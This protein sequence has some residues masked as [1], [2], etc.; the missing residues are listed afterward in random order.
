MSGQTRTQTRYDA[1]VVGAGPNGLAAAIAL[2]QA[3]RSVVVYEAAETVGGGSR[4]KELTLPGFRHDVCSAI[5]PLGVASP[6][7]RSLPLARY[8]LEWV[9][10]PAPLAHPLD[11]GAAVLERSLGGMEASLGKQDAQAWRDLFAPPVEHWE[12]LAQGI[13]GPLRLGFQ[14]AHPL[15]SL[16]MARFAVSALQ[17]ARML[18]ERTFHGERARALCGGMGAHSMLPL[19]QPA[20]AAI[21]LVLGTLA[22]RVGWPFPKGGSQALADALAAHLRALGGKIVTGVEVKSLRELPRSRA[23]LFDVTPRQALR[24]AGDALPAG[25][26][27]RLGRYRYGPGVF[28]VDYALDGPIPWMDAICARAG[29][30][31]VG[32][33]LDE[34]SASEHGVARGV[35]PERP[36][37][38]L[39]QQSLFDST[40]APEGKHTAWAYCHVPNGCD[41][42]MTAR[43]EA[44]IERFAPGFRD[45]ILARHTMAPAQMQAYNANYIGGDINGGVQDLGQLFTRPVAR[46]DPY[47]TPNKRLYFCSSSTPPGGG[48]HGMCGYYAARSALRAVL[49]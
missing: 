42:D 22:H 7:F 28:K 3:G 38:L 25:Y 13:L 33:T 11:D 5:H 46:L 48:V 49:A 45:R 39:A 41:V 21:A 18:A 35:A 40:R 8:G 12:S 26:R 1:V 14:L 27:A 10:P 44:Q 36:F 31:H 15:I 43:I 34:I 32:G 19:E 47:S 29:T 9:Y 37:V 2:A 23:V 6:F 16:Q 4:T 17:P 30:V 20:S 24:I